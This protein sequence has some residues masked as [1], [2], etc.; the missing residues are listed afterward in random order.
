M[1]NLK[2]V[3]EAKY[4]NNAAKQG[5]NLEKKVNLYLYTFLFDLDT[6]Q[7]KSLTLDFDCKYQ[8]KTW[9]GRIIKKKTDQVEHR[10]EL[11]DQS[12]EL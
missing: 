1:G 12:D 11:S 10:D 5:Y 7:K 8:K 6:V 9:P 2:D 3:A 4:S